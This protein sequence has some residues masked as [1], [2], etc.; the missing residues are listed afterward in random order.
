MAD[1]QNKLYRKQALQQVSSPENLDQSLQI[2]NSLGWVAV[3]TLG[4]I[5]AAALVWGIWGSI[6]TKVSTQGIFLHQSGI[7]N[8]QTQASGKLTNISVSVGDSVSGGTVI[9]T[10]RLENLE[11]RIE[12]EKAALQ[13]LKKE[14]RLYVA[15]ASEKLQLSEQSRREQEEKLRESLTAQEEQIAFL[16]EKLE[17]MLPLYEDQLITRQK[18]V[19]VQG[20]LSQARIER[21][22]IL[23]QI[24]TLENNFL[25]QKNS[26]ALDT[27]QNYNN[28]FAQQRN[29]N[30]L[31]RQKDR[32]SKIRSD[33]NGTIVELLVF[34]GELVTADAAIARV[35]P[36]AP[37]Y[38]VILFASPYDGKKIEPG[39]EAQVS[40][41]TVSR[42][43]YGS[44]V[45][46]VTSVSE[47]PASPQRLNNLLEN[48]S[49]INT[50][51]QSGPP[52][53]VVVELKYDEDTG[54]F[55]W[56]SSKTPPYQIGIGTLCTAT[57]TV[58][59]Q[60]PISLVIPILEETAGL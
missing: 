59:T 25:E 12:D 17:G 29:V 33:F 53:I 20:Q 2:S 31:I 24:S 18:V 8:I 30:N 27:L 52:I 36:R 7:A 45:A 9:A 43:E 39:M 4:V 19:D 34:E 46:T 23:N 50:V 22:D 6:A 5:L 1:N 15:N 14:H 57:V 26:F 28:V 58:K 55:V 32:Q 51:S 37:D 16:E 38:P 48:E 10:M 41:S 40:P 49:L 54:N 3:A 21:A 47:V 35:S 11:Q 13:D 60:S 44:M 56:T 42:D